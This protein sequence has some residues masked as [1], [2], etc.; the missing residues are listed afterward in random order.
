MKH[1]FLIIFSFFAFTVFSQAQPT[2]KI[3]I[4]KSGFARAKTLREL[5]PSLPKD[6]AI[7]TYQFAIDT[8]ELKKTLSMKGNKITTDLKSI[9]KGMKA[10]Q[11]FFI[12]NVK[13]DCKTTFKKNYTFVIS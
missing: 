7:T 5:I 1:F 9:V 4:S 3:K 12:E 6:C 2:G 13:S 10:G 11:K 8:P